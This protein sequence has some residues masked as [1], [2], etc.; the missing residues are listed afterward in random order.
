MRQ[1][2]CFLLLLLLLGTSNMNAQEKERDPRIFT[3]LNSV[4]PDTVYVNEPFLVYHHVQGNFN[5]IKIKEIEYKPSDVE[6][7]ESIVKP[8][9]LFLRFF[10]YVEDKSAKCIN[11]N[12]LP[13]IEVQEYFLVN[14]L[15][16][17]KPGQIIIPKLII[18]LDTR[19]VSSKEKEIVVLPQRVDGLDKIKSLKISSKPQFNPVKECYPQFEFDIVIDGYYTELQNLEIDLK[20]VEKY[21]SS[22]FEILKP[23]KDVIGMLSPYKDYDNNPHL[24]SYNSYTWLLK[25]KKKMKVELPK[26]RIKLE[27]KR[28]TYSLD[29]F[30]V[31]NCPEGKGLT[32]QLPNN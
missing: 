19:L 26:I 17:N 27:G 29:A 12:E 2:I 25:P 10:N 32:P 1:T 14:E 5:N 13:N 16:A 28:E 8:K 9:W 30:E 24:K 6:G 18:D 4:I 11:I 15:R 3:I 22:K 7:L 20:K 23:R 21:L 31:V